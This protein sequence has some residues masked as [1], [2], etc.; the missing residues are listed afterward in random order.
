MSGYVEPLV[1][2]DEEHEWYTHLCGFTPQQG[3]DCDECS[4]EERVRCMREHTTE[5]SLAAAMHGE[6]S[7]EEA[8]RAY[9]E[10]MPTYIRI[11]R[12]AGV[13]GV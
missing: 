9:W 5:L 3:L 8:L 11:M 13:E 6:L 12:G 2:G 4:D 7:R 1:L 10:F